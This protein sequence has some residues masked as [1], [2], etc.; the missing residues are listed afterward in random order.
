MEIQFNGKR[1]LVTGGGRGIGKQIAVLLDEM[2]A[3]VTVIDKIQED[4]DSLSKEIS[5]KTIN[6]DISDASSARQAAEQAGD[7]D[8]LVNC[9]G[10]RVWP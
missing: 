4:M 5:C 8:L 6:A 3:E 1:A 7:I 2:G 9:A 10:M